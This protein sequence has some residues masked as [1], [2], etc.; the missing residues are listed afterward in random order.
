MSK[1]RK[2]WD[3]E[4]HSRALSR[5]DSRDNN[6]VWPAAMFERKLFLAGS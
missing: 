5:P 4:M 1:W 6:Y 3:F 2:E